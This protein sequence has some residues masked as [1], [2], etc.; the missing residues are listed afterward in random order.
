MAQAKR[1][2]IE[3]ALTFLLEKNEP[4]NN[5]IGDYR[6][7]IDRE[8]KQMIKVRKDVFSRKW[9]LDQI[10]KSFDNY[11]MDKLNRKEENLQSNEQLYKL[12]IPII[13]N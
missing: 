2:Q 10:R 8:L 9:Y 1:P 13:Q 12:C 4:K 5:R 11:Q 6:R 3:E 7:I